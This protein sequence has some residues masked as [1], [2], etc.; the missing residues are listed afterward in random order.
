MPSVPDYIYAQH[1]DTLFANLFIASDAKIDINNSTIN[2]T[3]KTDYP[4]NGQVSFQITTEKDVGFSLNVRIPGWAQ[5][6]P[7]PSDLYRY[8]DEST[9]DVKL[10]VNGAQFSIDLNKGYASINRMWSDGDVVKL[11]LPMPVRR[12]IAHKKVEENS[13]KVALERGPL[14]YC[15][16]GIDNGGK[17]FHAHMPHDAQFTI[18]HHNDMLKGI[19]TIYAKSERHDGR[20]TELIAIPY[21]SWSHRGVG[22]MAVWIKRQ[23]D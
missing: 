22:E 23:S 18:E 19:T 11:D 4:W 20:Q 15:V 7:V 9:N 16:E 14:V 10:Y 6:I 3:Q 12:V 1:G 2:V 8:G 5:G 17:A 13:A 21:Y